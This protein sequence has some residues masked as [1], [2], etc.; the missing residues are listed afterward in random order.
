MTAP[1]LRPR[2]LRENTILRNAITETYIRP[3]HLIYPMFVGD[4]DTPYEIKG[5]PGITKYPINELVNEIEKLVSC[6]L[7]SFLIFG[8]PNNKD[9]I[10]SA[11]IEHHGV[12]PKALRA[13]RK[14][15]GNAALIATD[16]C[17]CSYTDS[18]HCGIIKDG[19]VDNDSSIDIIAQMAL[20]HAQAGADL[21]APS[22][23]MDGRV[24]CIRELLDANNFSHT[25]IMSYAVKYASNLYGPFRN[26]ADSTPAFGDRRGYQLDYHNRR[27]AIREAI[28]DEQEGADILMVKPGV[29]YLDIIRDLYEHTNLPIAAY[30]VSGEYAMIRYAAINNAIDERGVVN[31]TWTAM[32]RAGAQ[33]ILSYHAAIAIQENWLL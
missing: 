2:R 18:G 24:R 11:A 3:E 10:A 12:V 14:A 8:T 19:R 33:L 29:T 4:I 25:P 21:V 1:F 28:L 6:G 5:M 23:M 9:A 20:T 31:E 26:A 7:K 17:L 22:D 30:Q 27:D 15:I 13:I 32:R 16:V